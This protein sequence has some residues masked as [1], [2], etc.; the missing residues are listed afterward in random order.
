MTDGPRIHYVKTSDGVNIAYGTV[1]S[2]SPLVKLRGGPMSTA[3]RTPKA[4][5]WRSRG[6]A[7]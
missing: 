1:G 2:G 3:G 7:A 4:R 6:P 5:R